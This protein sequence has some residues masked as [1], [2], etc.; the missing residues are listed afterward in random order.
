MTPPGPS[1][2]SASNAH[3]PDITTLR[4]DPGHEREDLA[5]TGR[6]RRLERGPS[7]A[8]PNDLRNDLGI[9]R[10]PSGRD[11]R[12]RVHE[13]ADVCNAILEQVPHTRRALGEK[14]RRISRL[15]V[16]RED[17]DADPRL[18]AA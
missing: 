17:Q 16:L 10:R 7:A 8:C 18:L 11:A 3:E 4:R 6:E 9:E 1:P 13:L 12:E 14:L 2:C 5:L 15:Q